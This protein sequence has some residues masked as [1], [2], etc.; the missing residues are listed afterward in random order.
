[1]AELIAVII[2]ASL[3]LAGF[4]ISALLTPIVSGIIAKRG[5]NGKSK[6]Q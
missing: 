2:L 3:I 5:E 4:F 6:K 1:M